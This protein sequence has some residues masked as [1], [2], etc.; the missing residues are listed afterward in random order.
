MNVVGVVV[1]A[2]PP[3]DPI[4]SD[5]STT[6]GGASERCTHTAQRRLLLLG[7]ARCGGVVDG[8]AA[9]RRGAYGGEYLR[10]GLR[11]RARGARRLTKDLVKLEQENTTKSIDGAG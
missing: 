3:R 8:T 11:L 4:R 2:S 6:T 10:A 7:P 9:Q 1:L 5:P